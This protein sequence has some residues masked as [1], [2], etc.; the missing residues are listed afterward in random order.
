MAERTKSGGEV[1]MQC[2]IDDQGVRFRRIWGFMVLGVALMTGLLAAW[3]GV[4]WVWIIAG[5]SA[6]AGGFA[7]FESR[8]RWCA[9]RAMGIKTRI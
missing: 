6:G 5:A 3:S 7:L 2:N 8:Q 1:S 9:L 4:W